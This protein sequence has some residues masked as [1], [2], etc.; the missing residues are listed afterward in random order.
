MGP[1]EIYF[2]KLRHYTP[3]EFVSAYMISHTHTKLSAA[4]LTDILN[5]VLNR[6]RSSKKN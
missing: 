6:H 3:E 2:E 5:T 1:A 4:T